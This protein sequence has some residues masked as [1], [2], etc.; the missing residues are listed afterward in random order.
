MLLPETLKLHNKVRFDFHYIYFLPWKDQMVESLLSNEGKV[1]CFEARNNIELLFQVAKVV[2]YAKSNNVQLIHAHLPWAG[3]ISRIVGRFTN[4]PVIYTEHNKQ[5]RYHRL[6]RIMNLATMNWLTHIIAVSQD[7]ASSIEKHKPKVRPPLQ[8]ILNGV[9]TTHFAREGFSGEE[10]RTS[11]KIPVHV[12]VI[13]TVAVFRFQ[14]RLDV[15]IEIAS[16]ILKRLPAAHFIVVGDGPL[17]TMLIQKRADLGLQE[18]IHFVGLKQEV[19]PYLAAF[20]LYMISS[21]FEGLPIALLEA[22]SFECPIISTDAGGIKEVVR[23]EIEGML[24][25][26]DAPEKLTDLAVDLLNSPVKLKSLAIQARR[27]IVDSFGME[28]MVNELEILYSSLLTGS[29]QT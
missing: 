28:K 2:R 26:V 18:R 17:K 6:T 24:C 25:D 27:R 3:I 22:M 21:V 29:S 20:D 14:K 19:R 4:I 16:N 9:N 7:V 12:P 13:G 23:H 1:V 10:I 5:E 15:W 8:V 11:L